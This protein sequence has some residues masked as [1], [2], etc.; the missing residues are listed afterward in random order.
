MDDNNNISLGLFIFYYHLEYT[1]ICLSSPSV[2]MVFIFSSMH[3]SGEQLDQYTGVAASLR[4]PLPE[5]AVLCGSD[6]SDDDSDE[7]INDNNSHE[8]VYC[9]IM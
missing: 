8:D 1:N 2:I 5:V 4:F 6:D 3:I 7:E 9:D